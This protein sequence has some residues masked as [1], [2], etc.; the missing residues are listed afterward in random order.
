MSPDELRNVDLSVAIGELDRPQFNIVQRQVVAARAGRADANVTD[1]NRAIVAALDATGL[2]KGRGQID[3]RGRLLTAINSEVQARR[4]ASPGGRLSNEDR[5]KAIKY[6]I[7]Q[8]MLGIG[9][10]RGPRE[11][12]AAL[13][14]QVGVSSQARAARQLR[15][16]TN[17]VAT[18]LGA[19]KPFTPQ[20]EIRIQ[21]TTFA[22]IPPAARRAIVSVLREN[23]VRAPSQLEVRA[24]YILGLRAATNQGE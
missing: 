7:D 14:A 17:G 23:G 4:E 22:S 10:W 12:S 15:P 6:S 13:E 3:D 5:D 18:L 19:D 21:E 8:Y 1:D 2:K 11:N 24:A 20:E 16:Q 9:S